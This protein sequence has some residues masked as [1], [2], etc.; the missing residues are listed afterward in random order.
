M[1]DIKKKMKGY[2]GYILFCMLLCLSGCNR[3][4]SDGLEELQIE[5]SKEEKSEALEENSDADDDKKTVAED[6]K[7]AAVFV[8]VCGAVHQPGVYEMTEDARLYEVIA[9]AGGLKEDAAGEMVNQARLVEDGERVYIPTKEE[10]AAGMLEN[11]AGES[12]TSGDSTGNS[13]A[14]KV[15]LNTAGKEE[16]MTLPGIGESKADS[17]L[18]YR[19][20]HGSF[21]STEELMQI[22]GI[23][24]GV[25]NKIKD[26]ITV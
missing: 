13:E 9:L 22:S 17:I 15:N 16:L 26:N 19:E 14:K 5:T 23:K 10:A 7:K 25:Y 18:S 3:Q 6:S 21:Q 1:K 2:T 4:E 12:T 11:A 20:E 8:Y 24:E